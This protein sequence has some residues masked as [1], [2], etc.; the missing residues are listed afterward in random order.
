[1]MRRIKDELT[2]TK[3]QNASLQADLEAARGVASPALNGSTRSRMNGRGTPSSEDGNDPAIRTQL[4]EAQRQAQRVVAENRD[5]RGRLDALER[6]LEEIREHLTAT[7][8]ESDDRMTRVEDLEQEIERLQQSLV[9]ARGGHEDSFVDQLANENVVLKRENEELTHKIGLLLE[10]EPD[11]GRARPI[12][13]ISQ[14]RA[15]TSSSENA[16]AYD[17]FSNE[18]D[19]WQRHIAGS[20]STRRPDSD[21][22]S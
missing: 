12:S 4:I 15:S 6:E 19:G 3:A 10:A 18:L 17:D 7:Q 5:L 22:E 16:M 21:Y 9:V 13:G 2:K 11:Y 14:R 20:G 1:M 8:H